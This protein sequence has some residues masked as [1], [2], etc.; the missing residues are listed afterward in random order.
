MH[1]DYT[2]SLE[3]VH[4]KFLLP[5]VCSKKTL[6]PGPKCSEEISLDECFE[7]K[8]AENE[9]K[10]AMATI[11]CTNQDSP[12]EDPGQLLMVS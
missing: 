6:I 10:T 7:D 8:A 5:H 11:K 1:V 2:C 9:L 3:C 4:R 12:W